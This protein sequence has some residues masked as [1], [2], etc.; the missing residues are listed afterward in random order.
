MIVSSCLK[1]LSFA[2]KFRKKTDLSDDM[3]SY[4]DKY[5][6]AT[7]FSVLPINISRILSMFGSDKNLP[8]RH[9]YGETYQSLFQP[10]RYKPV[11]IL[12]IGL[13]YGSSLLTWRWFFPLGTIIGIDIAP[14][15]NISGKRIKIYTGS[16]YSE[17]FLQG[18]CK[19]EGY[20]DIVIDDGSHMSKHQ[21]FSFEIIFS[22]LKDCGIYV[23]E[24]IQTSFWNEEIIGEAWD[25]KHF[26][27]P[28]FSKTCYGYFLELSKYINHAE[29]LTLEGVDQRKLSLAKEIKRITFEHNMIIIWKGKNEEN[30]NL[31]HRQASL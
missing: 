8:G 31:I 14:K 2:R 24:D 5:F 17:E 20:F 25:G 6:L 15:V 21:I 28:E 9:S 13:L 4:R 3:A 22:Y 19:K 16:Q 7:I 10:M 26:N 23:V 30:S 27:D 1:L 29:F 11:K 12:E 18:V